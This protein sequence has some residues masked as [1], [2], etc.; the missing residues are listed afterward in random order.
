MQMQREI[1]GS[2]YVKNFVFDRAW[3]LAGRH[4]PAAPNARE[5]AVVQA[6]DCQVLQILDLMWS[7]L[8]FW[9]GC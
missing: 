2:F 4:A 5:E 8:L 7:Q 6:A 3:S 1:R 9:A